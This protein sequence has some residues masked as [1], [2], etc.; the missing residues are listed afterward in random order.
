MNSNPS[1]NRKSWSAAVLLHDFSIFVFSWLALIGVAHAGLSITA[2]TVDGGASVS[3][4]PGGSV[5]VSY[6]VSVTGGGDEVEGTDWR[7]STTAPGTV[8]CANSA[9]DSPNNTNGTYTTVFTA[10][11]PVTPGTYNLYLIAN[12]KDDCTGGTSSATFVLSNAIVVQSTLTIGN[13]SVTE[14]NSGMTNATFTVTLSP[15]SASNVSFNYASGGTATGGASCTV[16][17]DYITTSSSKTITA[18]ATSTTIDVPVCGDTTYEANETFTLTLSGVSSGA[19]LGTPSVG[20]GTISNDDIPSPLA[21]YTL[22]DQT[23]NDSSGNSYNGAVGGT[24]GTA[25]TFSNA[26]PAVGTTTGTCGYRAFNRPDKT[27]IYLPT[28]FPNLGASGSAFTITAWIRTTDR[29]Q[30]GQRILIDDES[31]SGGFGFS[32]GDGGAGMVRFFSRGTSSALILDT[33]NAITNNNV[34]Y[35]VAAVADVPNKT[36]HIYVFS[37]AGTLLSHVQATWTEAS[38]G[39]DTRVVSI[40]GETNASGENTGAFGFAG[41]IDEV[42]VYTNALSQTQLDTIRTTTRTCPAD[43][44]APGL[45]NACEVTSTKCTP[46]TLPTVTYALLND[47]TAGV[48]FAL[49]GVAL[50]SGGTL[51]T[52]CS[53]NVSVDLVANTTTGVALGAGNCPVSQTSTIALGAK[54]FASGRVALTGITVP[55]VYADVRVKYTYAGGVCGSATTVCSTDNFAVSSAGPDHVEIVHDGQGGVCSGDT[56]TLKACADAACSSLYTGGG[57]S[58]SLT[59]ATGWTSNPVT[60]GTSGT[61]SATY[62]T[63]LAGTTRYAITSHTFLCDNT[64]TATASNA[65]TEC[66]VA[67]AN[68]EFVI[69]ATDSLGNVPVAGRPHRMTLTAYRQQAGQCGI[70]TNYRNNKTLKAWY[71]NGAGVTPSPLP[72]LSLSADCSGAIPASGLPAT[73]PGSTNVTLNFTN[74]VVDPLYLCTGGCRQVFSCVQGCES[75]HPDGN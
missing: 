56:V 70:S 11:A 71:S 16:G 24:G 43:V 50:L 65:T 25:P 72:T 23:W 55:A 21:I 40:G 47:K 39:S 31:D 45:F 62:T 12:D 10:T 60:I 32:L 33:G 17:I 74:G 7:I 14:G 5:T 59:P 36:K 4:A 13:A 28:T 42:R 19:T 37:T 48:P 41:N 26:T 61:A 30:S 15:A 58:V 44:V 57:V 54:T 8:T 35:F 51:N 68:N 6:T 18:G 2:A 38:F 22:D 64:S 1:R 46:T 73:E 63:D 67:F 27:Y 69:A 66:D 52:A 75:D 53:G 3:V 9:P 49:D 34:W 20:T 29:T